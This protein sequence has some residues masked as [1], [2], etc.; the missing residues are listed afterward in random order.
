MTPMT[1]STGRER[2][3]R[4]SEPDANGVF[5]RGGFSSAFDERH[6]TDANQKRV[7]SYRELVEYLIGAEYAADE[8]IHD[9]IS[10]LR[11]RALPEGAV[12]VA[13]GIYCWDLDEGKRLWITR[14]LNFF[15][16]SRLAVSRTPR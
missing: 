11:S 10:A 1:P 4:Q 6:P 14:Q 2:R 15:V 9:L 16:D 3:V 13:E 12:L 5:V 8:V 7:A